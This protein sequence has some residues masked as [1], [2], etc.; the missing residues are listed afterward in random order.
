MPPR[1]SIEEGRGNLSES[2]RIMGNCFTLLIAISVILTVFFQI[3]SEPLLLI[4]GASEAT[5]GY[6][7]DYMRIYT[8]GTSSYS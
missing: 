1:A 4:F 6:A 3:F 5:I 8:M 7:M 2:E